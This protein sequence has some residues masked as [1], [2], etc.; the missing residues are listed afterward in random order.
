MAGLTL[1]LSDE[2]GVTDI[3]CAGADAVLKSVRLELLPSLDCRVLKATPVV[4]TVMLAVAEE[5]PL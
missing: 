4:E 3:A 1:W 2:L 5:T